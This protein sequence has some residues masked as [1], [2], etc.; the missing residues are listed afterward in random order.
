METPVK[1]FSVPSVGVGIS[2]TESI[3]LTEGIHTVY[4]GVYA[5]ASGVSVGDYTFVYRLYY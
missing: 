4:V 2:A 5:S 3:S 1:A